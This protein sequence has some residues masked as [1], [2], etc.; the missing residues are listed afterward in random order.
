[1]QPKY[2]F[3]LCIQL[4]NDIMPETKEADALMGLLQR[5]GFYGVELN[6]TDLSYPAQSWSDYLARFGLKM[7]MIA[8]GAYA[9]LHGLAL[10]SANKAVRE[11]T[12]AALR[13]IAT[14]AAEVKAGVICGYLKGGLDACDQA[15]TDSEE[16]IRQWCDEVGTPIYFEATNRY[17]SSLL[18]QVSD[19]YQFVGGN[20]FLLPDTYH[21]N[22]EER[23][24]VASL[25]EARG[26]FRNLHISDNNR[27]FPGFGAIDFYR[28]FSAL[29]AFGYG[30]T[31][32]IEGRNF[33]SLER[34]I[35]ISAQ[36]LENISSRLSIESK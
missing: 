19:V 18:N 27:Y 26:F 21:M 5:L 22:I 36:Y 29:K 20:I 8:T 13:D 32:S 14:Y 9:K 2:L 15:F 1:M 24:T 17:E 4:G 3:P 34:D 6:I 35:E 7:T 10:G 28:I 25:I 12:V 33:Y 16:E 11:K 30:G 31:V 23:N